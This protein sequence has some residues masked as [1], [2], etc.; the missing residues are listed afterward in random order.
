MEHKH[1]HV[2]YIPSWLQFTFQWKQ[3][4][5]TKW[6]WDR[7]EWSGSKL[8][9][10][11]PAES[12]SLIHFIRSIRIWTRAVQLLLRCRPRCN[13]RHSAQTSRSHW[14]WSC[15]KTF[16]ICFSPFIFYVNNVRILQCSA[17]AR[18]TYWLALVH[19][20]A[21][22]QPKKK[23]WPPSYIR[24]D[25]QNKIKH[26]KRSNS[27]PYSKLEQ[28]FIVEIESNFVRIS[29]IRIHWCF[30]TEKVI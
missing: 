4:S 5:R 25:L 15:I 20:R 22:W 11:L 14:P 9:S 7:R 30:C 8:C 16:G 13:F 28:P 2:I 12:N 3:L 17:C 6:K 21:N 18:C 24:S 26:P 19:V 29:F 1:R 23:T 27:N 10:L